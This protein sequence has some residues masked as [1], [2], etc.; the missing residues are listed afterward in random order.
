MNRYQFTN[1]AVEDLST[2]WNC[3]FDIWSKIRA[4]EYYAEL[5]DK[6]VNMVGEPNLG[7]SYSGIISAVKGVKI[8][9]HIIFYRV[10]NKDLIEI[11]RIIHERLDLRSRMGE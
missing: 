8:N 2:V 11:E 9:K 5:V 7:R 3:A 6:C 1:K 4:D 10:I